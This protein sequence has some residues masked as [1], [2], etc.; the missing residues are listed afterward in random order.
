MK[1]NTDTRRFVVDAAALQRD[2]DKTPL[3]QWAEPLIKALASREDAL[4]HGE[5]A[6]WRA[7]VEALPVLDVAEIDLNHEDG[8]NVVCN[9][10][11]SSTQQH[12]RSQLQTL[13]PWRKG[14]FT[15][16]GIQIDSEWRSDWKWNR[17]LPH[18]T[19]LSGRTVLDVGC[20]NGYHL[21]RMRAA[22]ASTVLGIDPVL[23][24]VQQFSACQHY[25]NDPAVQLLPLTLDAMP[26][27]M[28]VFD[29]AFS[30]GVLY[31]RKDPHAHINELLNCLR[32]GGE[33]VLETLVSLGEEDSQITL[34]SR[35]AR[36][37]NINILPSVARIA[38]WLD[39][40]GFVGVRCV[41]VDITS[42]LE[43]RTTEWMQQESL[44]NALDADNKS[45][46]I[47]GLPRPRRAIFLAQAP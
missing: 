41:S 14:P 45:L 38:R 6:R 7:A 16:A 36:M 5:F 21:W 19:A 35:Y 33:L 3:K 44:L 43:Q 47:E 34:D 42:V 18:I 17:L 31:H 23:L 24:F 25:I 20:G 22:G 37:R 8:V 32:P 4:L 28:Q 1:H 15:I 26:A 29:T 10:I 40:A 13:M 2:L 39:D 9:G 46:T 30:M 27:A 12:L 11:D